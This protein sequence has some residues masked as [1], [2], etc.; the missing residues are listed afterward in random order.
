VRSASLIRP[1]TTTFLKE[2]VALSGERQ[3]LVI[4]EEELQP[5]SRSRKGKKKEYE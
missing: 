2:R 1:N 5:H 4:F 3:E